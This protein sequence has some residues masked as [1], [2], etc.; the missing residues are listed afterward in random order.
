M[1]L[2]AC[3]QMLK[4]TDQLNSATFIENGCPTRLEDIGIDKIKHTQ[5]TNDTISSSGYALLIPATKVNILRLSSLLPIEVV[6]SNLKPI[7]KVGGIFNGGKKLELYWL[8]IAVDTNSLNDF[9]IREDE[10]RGM[11]INMLTM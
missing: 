8:E 1:E 10:L 11:F 2:H 7:G 3:L 6:S 5:P 9:L 4:E